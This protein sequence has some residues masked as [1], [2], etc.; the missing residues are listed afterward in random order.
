MKVAFY[1]LG[2]KVNQY[3]TQAIRETFLQAAFEEVGPHD[4][5]DVYIVNSCTVTHLADRKSR[6]AIR[7]MKRL[8]PDSIIAVTGCYAQMN[9]EEIGHIQGVSL[10][11]GTNEK[12]VILREV[13]KI[14]NKPGEEA[15]YKRLE[16]NE[17]CDYEETGSIVSM[18]SRTR[19]YVKVQEGCDRFCSY[20][21]IPYARGIIR[22]RSPISIKEE[23]GDLANKG[24]KEIIL[25]GINTALYG[26]EKGFGEKYHHEFLSLGIKRSLEGV[27]PLVEMLENMPGQFRLRLGSLEPNVVNSLDV[28][29]LMAYK[30]LCHHLHLSL[31]SGSDRVLLAMNRRYSRK[32]YQD[33]LDE[34]GKVD[35][36]YG[37]T[38]DIIVGFPGETEDDFQE[39]LSLVE[40]Q[41]FCKIHIFPY[42]KRQG[43]KAAQM[44]D[45]V[46]PSIVKDRITRLQRAAED[47]QNRFLERNLGAQ[48]EVLIE[49]YDDKALEYIGYSDN[50]IRVFVKS[51]EDILNQIVRPSLKRVYKNGLLGVI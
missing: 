18:E 7:R 23:V 22:S 33:I 29:E 10:V 11:V 49:E 26:R 32:D 24:F 16:Y 31:Q 27:G 50:Y 45:Q 4:W 13:L 47:S 25:T 48:R 38:T 46:D 39:T 35:T 1:T 34:L 42:S 17:I 3:E 19:A 6:Q 28:I 14:I 21:I 36:N 44:L 8:N 51:E 20:C 2:C 37:V 41:N 43:T 5:A 12:S 9:P 30:R 15:I 40:G